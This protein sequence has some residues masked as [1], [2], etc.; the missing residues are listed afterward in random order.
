M[1]VGNHIIGR[2]VGPSY[3]PG[4]SQGRSSAFAPMVNPSPPATAIQAPSTTMPQSNPESDQAML[5]YLMH[6]GNM[7]PIRMPV[8]IRRF[9]DEGG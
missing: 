2:P 1:K 8:G 3:V 7:A 6:R 9:T 5:N 4:T